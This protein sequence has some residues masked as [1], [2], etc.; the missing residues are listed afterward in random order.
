MKDVNFCYPSCSERRQENAPHLDTAYVFSVLRNLLQS[1]LPLAVSC[2]P[3]TTPTGTALTVELEVTDTT[4]RLEDV[5]V[6]FMCPP[7]ANP[8]VLRTDAG[9]TEHDG[10]SVHW[11]LPEMGEALAAATIELTANTSLGTLMPFSVELRSKQNICN[12]EVL[13]CNHMETKA[14]IPFCLT[15]SVEYLLTVNP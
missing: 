12:V 14:E 15:R 9:T 11:F 10:V 5:H 2:W 1:L 8:Q 7:Q 3:S 13:Q 6:S 4:K